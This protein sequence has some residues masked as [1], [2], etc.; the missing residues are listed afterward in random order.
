MDSD[1]DSK[2]DL[3]TTVVRANDSKRTDTNNNNINDVGKAVASTGTTSSSTSSATTSE[4]MNKNKNEKENNN[5]N[6]SDSGLGTGTETETRV[7]RRGGCT[8]LNRRSQSQSKSKSQSQSQS[9]NTNNT[10]TVHTSTYSTRASSTTKPTSA[11]AFI[12]GQQRRSTKI[13]SKRS[14]YLEDSRRKLASYGF[15]DASKYSISGNNMFYPKNVQDH[16]L[17]EFTRLVKP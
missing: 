5:D 9:T 12:T 10:K 1:L 17:Y 8:L 3:S 2:S 4:R 16:T 11:L 15:T 7:A 6:D 13:C 14:E